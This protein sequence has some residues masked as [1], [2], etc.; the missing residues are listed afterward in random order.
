MSNCPFEFYEMIQPKNVELFPEQLQNY[1][2]PASV[3][4]SPNKKRVRVWPFT[5]DTLGQNV[6]FTPSVDCSNT[7]PSIFNTTCKRTVFHHFTTDVFGIVYGGNFDGSSPF[8]L[9]EVHP[10][11]LVQILPIA[12][13]FDQIGPEELFEY[14]KI[15]SLE[16]RM[17]VFGGTVIPYTIYFEDIIVKSD[18]ITVVD[19]KEGTYRISLPKTVAGTDLRIE[20]GPTA[21]DFHR[22]YMRIQAMRQGRINTENEWI[23]L[24]SEN[25]KE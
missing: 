21:F 1:T 13:R 22:F 5:I 10:P 7:A 24:G 3:F 12:K 17:I 18:T 25:E 16:L 9:W 11:T 2:I 19:G 23:T 14:S 20:L 15:R 4:G 6:T 8:E